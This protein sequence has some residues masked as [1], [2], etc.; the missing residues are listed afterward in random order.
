MQLL[1]LGKRFS[2]AYANV[3]GCDSCV[4]MYMFA[5]PC[6]RVSLTSQFSE[7]SEDIFLL[8]DPRN[9][10][11][12]AP[13]PAGLFNNKQAAPALLWS[14]NPRTSRRLAPEMERRGTLLYGSSAWYEGGMPHLRDGIVC[15][16][17]PE[18]ILTPSA[19]VIRTFN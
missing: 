9:Y 16:N 15:T 8:V 6:Q 3:C 19:Y 7:S 5:S 2:S 13:S 17:R 12:N 1:K 4:C 18:Q 10:G 14:R 11:V